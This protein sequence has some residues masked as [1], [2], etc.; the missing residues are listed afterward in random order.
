ADDGPTGF[1]PLGLLETTPIEVFANLP[2]GRPLPAGWQLSHAAIASV[3]AR[4]GGCRG[5]G[6]SQDRLGLRDEP[7]DLLV[8]AH[9]PFPSALTIM[10]NTM[11]VTMLASS[12]PQ[13]TA[14]K[15]P[16]CFRGCCW[17]VGGGT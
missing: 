14:P 7:S 9:S 11:T 8:A 4:S 2:K 1:A 6:R 13:N 12:T 16:I 10:A 15:V 3:S 5:L 17:F